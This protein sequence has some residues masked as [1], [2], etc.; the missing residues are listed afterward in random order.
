ME[1]SLVET[2]DTHFD[3]VTGILPDLGVALAVFLAFL[4]V[5]W[6]LGRLVRLALLRRGDSVHAGFLGKLPAWLFAVVGLIV[7]ADLLGL[8]S[9]ATGLLAGGGATAIILGFAFREIGENLL[10]GLF[11]VFSRPFRIGDLIQSGGLPEGTVKAVDLRNTHVRTADGRDLFIPNAHVFNQPLANF[12]RDGLRRP[13]F[14]VGVDYHDPLEAVRAAILAAV[15][16]LDGVLA[17]PEPRVSIVEFAPAFALLEVSVWINTFA[18]TDFALVQTAAME[19]CRRA[20]LDNG[21]TISGDA[22]TAIALSGR[23]DSGP[24][25]GTAGAREGEA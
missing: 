18:G 20:I 15:S 16:G 25:D 10:A 3:E 13:T 22:R 7:A 23:L 14:T 2:L 8:Q 19:S 12:T 11:L 24:E 17:E 1:P 21:W 9:V 5:G 6:L 4:A